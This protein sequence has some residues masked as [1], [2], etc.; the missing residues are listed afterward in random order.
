LRAGVIPYARDPEG[1]VNFLLG[2]EIFGKWSA[3]AGT[4]EFGETPR[5][6]GV[7]EFVEETMGLF[8]LSNVL[9]ATHDDD[10]IVLEDSKTITY[11]YF[12]EMEWER[13]ISYYFRNITQFLMGC[14]GG[15]KNK[16]GV[17]ILG[18]CNEGLFEKSEINWYSLIELEVMDEKRMREV[19][20]DGG[21]RMVKRL[22]S[23]KWD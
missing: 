10:K 1:V 6:A 3:F 11:L 8:N 13:S 21:Y 18:T 23:I 17:P 15:R 19:F 4:I 9:A 14:T 2:K 7:R 12:M 20:N 5:L 16:W 22:L